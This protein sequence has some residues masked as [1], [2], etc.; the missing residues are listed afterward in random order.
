MTSAAFAP[1]Q[2]PAG[3]DR[4]FFHEV[5][6]AEIREFLQRVIAYAR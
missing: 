6:N 3:F 5:R 4:A 2:D 1:S